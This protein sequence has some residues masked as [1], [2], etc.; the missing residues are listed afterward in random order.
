MYPLWPSEPRSRPAIGDGLLWDTSDGILRAFPL[1]CR[2]DGGACT[3]AAVVR[4]G[5]VERFTSPPAIVGDRL[6]VVSTAS[7][8][9]YDVAC[10]RGGSCDQ[11]WRAP[12][13]AINTALPTAAGSTVI[14]HPHSTLEVVAYPIACEPVDGRCDPIWRSEPG[15][16]AGADPVVVGDVVFTSSAEKGIEVFPVACARPCLPLATMEAP[17][18][19]SIVSPSGDLVVV[20]GEDGRLRAFGPPRR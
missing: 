15:R 8:V 19:G 20:V 16:T 6:V 13:G 18:P 2:D 4:A 7:L 3:P 14:V 17:G 9:I 12:L 11:R 5:G 1:G 10:A